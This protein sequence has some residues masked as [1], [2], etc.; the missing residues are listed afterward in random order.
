MHLEPFQLERYFAKYEF[1]AAYLLSPSDIEPLALRELL[2]MA[3][4]ERRLQWDNLWLGYTESQGHPEL[5]T[6]ISGLYANITEKQIIEVV[7]EEGIFI[8]TNTLLN[9]GDHIIVMSPCYQSLYEIAKSRGVTV[10]YWQPSEKWSFD[11]DDLQDLM[12]ANT[13]MLIINSPHNP[14]GAH[15]SHEEFSAIVD[16]ARENDLWL[17]SDEM[18]RF[19]EYD[20]NDRLPAACEVYEKAITLCG[21][22]KSF[23]L[24]GLRVGWLATQDES[25]MQRFIRFKDYTTICGSAPSEILALIALEARDKILRRNL[26]IIQTNLDYLEQFFLNN[27]DYFSWVKPVAGTITF[28]EYLGEES[29]AELGEKLVQEKGV[30]IVPASVYDYEG[31]YFRLGFGREN[32]HDALNLLQ[33]Y[34]EEDS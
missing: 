15:F 23:A 8:S 24:P 29:I 9:A 6:A 4:D 19:S 13:R 16:F 18:Y 28:A 34:I 7:P 11:V 32:M 31:N 20:E 2:A 1:S 25:A 12:Q 30:M 5:L 27:A 26:D 3:S 10:S 17:F 21:M 22:S 33:E 14:T